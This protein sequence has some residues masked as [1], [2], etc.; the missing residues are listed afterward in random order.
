MKKYQHIIWDWN[1]TLL[2]DVHLC[3]DLVNQLLQDHQKPILNLTSYH[4]VFDFP[5]IDY[6]RKIGFDFN[7]T[8]FATLCDRFIGAYDEQIRNCDL[9]AD[10]KSILQHTQSQGI[11]QS[12]L[13]AAKHDS[14]LDI[15]QH[16]EVAAY[17][18]KVSGLHNNQAGSKVDN[19]KRLIQSLS[20]NPTQVLLVG[21]TTHDAEVAHAIGVDCALIPIGHHPQKRLAQVP[22]ARVLPSLMDLKKLL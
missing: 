20:I 2:N 7:H 9:H 18:E 11:G 8:P 22:H 12:I 1:G 6:Y 14:L 5:V 3:I 15:V 4:E 21:D 19:G 10:A 13:S 16:Y 17:F